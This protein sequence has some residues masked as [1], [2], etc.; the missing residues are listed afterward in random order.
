MCQEDS[1]HL[2]ALG[3]LCWGVGGGMGL[4]CGTDKSQRANVCASLS[5]AKKQLNPGKARSISLYK[6]FTLR[7]LTGKQ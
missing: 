1:E 4:A 2:R 5:K 3:E 7:L 6:S